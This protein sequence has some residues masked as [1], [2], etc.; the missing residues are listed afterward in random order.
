MT[1]AVAR[2]TLQ[3]FGE[4]V[5]SSKHGAPDDR[6]L[7]WHANGA[8]PMKLSLGERRMLQ[9]LAAGAR[10][11]ELAAR[12]AL[13]LESVGRRIGNV[14]RKL[15]WDVRSGSLAFGDFSSMRQ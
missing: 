13:S 8:N 1:A 7:D 14:Y 3:F 10:S 12:M 15:S 9:L 2:Q 11:G 4:A 5:E 6:M